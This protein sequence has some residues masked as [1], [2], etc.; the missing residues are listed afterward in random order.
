MADPWIT[1]VK[2]V[3]IVILGYLLTL[4]CT[5]DISKV[6]IIFK[7]SWTMGGKTSAIT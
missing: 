1:G 7:I 5:F 4:F 3:L 2:Y 6:E